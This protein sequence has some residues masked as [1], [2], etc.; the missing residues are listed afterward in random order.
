MPASKNLH[1]FGRR[2]VQSQT[3]GPLSKAETPGWLGTPRSLAVLPIWFRGERRRKAKASRTP[4]PCLWNTTPL[5]RVNQRQR[6]GVLSKHRRR[7]LRPLVPYGQNRRPGISVCQPLAPPPPCGIPRRCGQSRLTLAPRRRTQSG[8]SAEHRAGCHCRWWAGGV[9]WPAKCIDRHAQSDGVN[10]LPCG[11]AS[12]RGEVDS[13]R[14]SGSPAAS[15]F[16]RCCDWLNR[17]VAQFSP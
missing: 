13:V 7:V 2:K 14:H 4:T 6:E 11:Q 10:A 9:A 1:K 12:A 17:V 3:A 8:A 15:R 5:I 16:Q